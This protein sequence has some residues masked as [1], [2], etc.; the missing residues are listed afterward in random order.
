MIPWADRPPEVANLLNPAFCGQVIF[1]CVQSHFDESDGAAM[2]YPLAFLVLPLILHR[3]TRETMRENRRYF[4]VWLNGNQ[5]VKIGFAQRARSL[6]PYARE[7]L[8]FLQQARIISVSD[9]N[10]MIIPG[11]ARLRRPRGRRFTEGDETKACLSRSAQLGKWFARANSPA[12]IYALLG[13]M[14]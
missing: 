6:V 10:A 7:A 2:S 8:T 9:S 11:A 5:H 3:D 12:T 4:A 1:R 13:V 14:P